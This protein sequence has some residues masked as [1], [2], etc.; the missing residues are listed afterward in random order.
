MN[1]RDKN[2]T[3]FGLDRSGLAVV[4]RLDE[5]DANV[6]VTD[7]KSEDELQSQIAELHG[8]SI[9]YA[10][11]RHDEQCIEKS[12]LIVVS[13]GVPLD[14]PILQRARSRDIPIIGEIEFASSLCQCPIVA[15][16]GTKGKSTTS[17]L[18]GDIL[19][20]S[21]RFENTYVAG[22]IGTPLSES[23]SMMRSDD[24]AVV[25][26][27]SFQLESTE[28]FHPE[29]SVILNIS[30]D[31]IDRHKSMENYLSAKKRIF[32]N[33][34]TEDYIVLNANHPI[35]R[36]FAQ[37]TAAKSIFFCSEDK[38]NF[39]G[40]FTRNGEIVS[41]LENKFTSVCMVDEIKLPGK[42]NLENVLAA[43]S[44][45]SILGVRSDFIRQSVL[46]F[47]GLEHA[48]EF[49]DEI[50]GVKFIN[51]TK[52]TN[53]EATR[54]ALET[55]SKPVMLI[56]GGYDKGNDYSPLIELIRDKVKG[57]FLLGPNTAK[58]EESLGEYAQIWHCQTM[59]EVVRL[60]YSRASQNDTVLLS[61]ANASFDLFEDYRDRGNQFKE[62]VK[63][64]G[65]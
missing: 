46:N 11:G 50:N 29:I 63:S 27:S 16:T 65:N 30:P 25:E 38:E 51:D 33:Q 28:T 44:V 37:D 57:L 32:A 53:V 10:L 7:L 61:P 35:V 41:N 64:I 59:N 43:V 52:A 49:V 22:N 9:N 48:F 54:V 34:T 24:I 1:Y 8:R 5:L 23:V 47:T 31:H 18:I 2:I 36:E 12:H 17:S 42:H 21:D 40:V 14:I 45:A 4:E 6:L 39:V 58:I 62:A 19:A 56:M 15:V 3:V 13:P 60:A 20:R 26:V 55:V